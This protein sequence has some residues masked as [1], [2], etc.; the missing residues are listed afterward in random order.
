[1]IAYSARQLVYNTAT[2]TFTGDAVALGCNLRDVVAVVS[3]RTG[4]HRVF[5]RVRD[6]R[7]DTIAEYRSTEDDLRLLV[8]VDPEQI[9]EAVAARMSPRG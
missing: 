7:D 3:P 5:V 4:A 1:M 2:R 9:R 8:R 6:N